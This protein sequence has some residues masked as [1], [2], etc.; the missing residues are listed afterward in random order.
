MDS[1]IY[2]M[3]CPHIH[4]HHWSTEEECR[5]I[6]YVLT[7]LC[8]HGC[9]SSL[10]INHGFEDKPP[11]EGF[12]VL[13]SVCDKFQ[14]KHK[15]CAIRGIRYDM[16]CSAIRFNTT[17]LDLRGISLITAKLCKPLEQTITI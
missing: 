17:T 12:P 4:I 7:E 9:H 13:K 11:Q 10:L 2:L 14:F 6:G 16:F 5:Q 8:C 1:S 15:N 3:D